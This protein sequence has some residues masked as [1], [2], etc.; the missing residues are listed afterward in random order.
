MLPEKLSASGPEKVNI[1][2]I[3]AEKY[4]IKI[5]KRRLPM[6]K[7]NGE[8]D[9]LVDTVGWGLFFI[10][11]GGLLLAGNQGWIKDEGWAYFAIGLGGI[12]MAGFLV[13]YFSNDVN[14]GKAFG[15]L[16]IGVSLMYVGFAFLN[17]LGNW[18]PLALVPIG[19][20]SIIKAFWRTSS[21]SSQINAR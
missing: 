13:R 19:I 4:L 15:G 2:N 5:P 16:V 17:G 9:R 8:L 18:W 14:R 11:L 1:R 12:F 10:L 20:A 7:W 6:K 21:E 3:Q